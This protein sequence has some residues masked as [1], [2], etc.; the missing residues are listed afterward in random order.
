MLKMTNNVK[1]YFKNNDQI[2]INGQ[3][4][5]QREYKRKSQQIII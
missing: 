3:N 5:S 1:I 4:I 2:K